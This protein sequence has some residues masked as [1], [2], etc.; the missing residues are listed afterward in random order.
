V[1]Y[2]AIYIPAKDQVLKF[3]IFNAMS[4]ARGSLMSIE[5]RLIYNLLPGDILLQS[6]F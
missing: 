6:R 2:L 3:A 5:P 1:G 4:I